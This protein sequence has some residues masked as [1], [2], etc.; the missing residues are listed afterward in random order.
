MEVNGLV[1]TLNMPKV[2]RRVKNGDGSEGVAGLPPYAPRAAFPVDEYPASPDT[3]M[4]GS[5]EASS[6]FVPIKPEHG[7][8][9]DLT[10]NNNHTHHVAAVVSVQGVNPLTGQKADPMRLEQYRKRC[11]KHDVEFQQDRYCPECKFKWHPQNYICTNNGSP[12]WIDGFR[13]EDGTVRQ[14][15]F[16]EEECKGV[17]AQVLGKERVFAIGIAFYL[18]KEPK[19]KPKHVYR[20]G[21]GYGS[22]IYTCSAGATAY[23]VAPEGL[24]SFLGAQPK[25]MTM[26]SAGS[27]RTRGAR[28]TKANVQD[29]KREVEASQKMLEIGAGAKIR[30]TLGADP[31]NLDFWQPEPAGL[32]YIN[33][34]DEA[35]ADRIIATGKRQDHEDG[36]LAGLNLREDD[37]AEKA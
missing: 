17:A 15:Y 8:W 13:T 33:Y 19:P 30:Q 20:G 35:T 16:T 6:Y 2:V 1:C 10:P 34:C 11:P 7:M 32:I 3:W 5:G 25:G 12:F 28:L 21:F 26:R 37:T 23:N 29:V 9:L 27:R 31:E 22:H 18:S 14:Y 24:E 4:H 36:F